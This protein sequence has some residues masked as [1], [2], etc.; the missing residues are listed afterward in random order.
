MYY[1]LPISNNTSSFQQGSHKGCLVDVICVYIN[2][3]ALN[4]L[5]INSTNLS[6]YVNSP[7]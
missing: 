2:P 7:L 3:S 1:S 6:E 5:L 4:S